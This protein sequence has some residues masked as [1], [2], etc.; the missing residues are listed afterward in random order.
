MTTDQPRLTA[1]DLGAA[2]G[3]RATLVQFSSTFCA[4]CRATRRVLE[5]VVGTEDGVAHVELDVA[6]RTDLGERFAVTT[7]PTVLVLDRDGVVVRR[8]SG[9]PTLAQ[10]RAAAAHAA[11]V[12]G[13]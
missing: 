5:R 4:P 2:L 9:A 10:A 11:A 12:S 6:D 7:T 13:G 3:P 8:A 1:D